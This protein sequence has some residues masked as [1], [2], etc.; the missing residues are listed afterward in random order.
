MDERTT[1]R[2]VWNCS[3][4]ITVSFTEM[5]QYQRDSHNDFYSAVK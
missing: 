1:N 5:K 2:E 3:G 4:D